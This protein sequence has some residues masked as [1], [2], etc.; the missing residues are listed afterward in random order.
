MLTLDDATPE[1]VE[2][3][4]QIAEQTW[5]PSYGEI[6]PPDQIRYMLDTLYDREALTHIMLKGIQK[7]VLLRNTAGVQGFVS[8]AMREK[9]PRMSKIHRLYVLPAWHRNRFGTILLDD[10]KRRLLSTDIHTVELNVARKNTAARKFYE[11]LGFHVSGEEEVPMGPY[12]LEDYV[13]RLTF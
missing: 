11:K 3:I 6:L 5:W 12:L 2:V 7:F 9:D 10:V 13:M 4:R 1:D 8:Y